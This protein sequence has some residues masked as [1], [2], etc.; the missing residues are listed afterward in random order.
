MAKTIK[1][2]TSR[3]GLLFTKRKILGAWLQEH[4]NGQTNQ[5]IL[6]QAIEGQGAK[7]QSFAKI[8]VRWKTFWHPQNEADVGSETN[9]H[10]SK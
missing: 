2:K 8:R 3:N 4:L 5:D 1:S 7:E 6:R 10:Y 9:H